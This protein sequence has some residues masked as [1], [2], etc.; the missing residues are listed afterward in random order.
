[1]TNQCE[2]CEDKYSPRTTGGSPQKFCSKQCKRFFEKSIRQWAY[3]QHAQG[4]LNL[5]ENIQEKLAL[6]KVEKRLSLPNVEEPSLFM[7]I[8]KKV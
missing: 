6:G 1:M 5:S 4:N 7:P 2:W 8:V 3:I